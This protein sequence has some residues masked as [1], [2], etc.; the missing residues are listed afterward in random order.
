[1]KCLSLLGCLALFACAKSPTNDNAGP[2]GGGGAGTAGTSGAGSGAGATATPDAAAGTAGTGGSSDSAIVGGALAVSDAAAGTVT[3]SG[4]AASGGA[5]SPSTYP[6]LTGPWNSNPA[7][8]D[9]AAQQGQLATLT[10]LTTDQLIARSTGAMSQPLG[11]APESATWLDL[12]QASA[13]ALNDQELAAY[14]KNGFVISQRQKYAN[15]FYGYQTIYAADL[16]IYVSADSILYALHRSYDRILMTVESSYLSSTLKQL[17]AGLRTSLATAGIGDNS[18]HD[19]GLLLGVAA[20]LLDSQATGI[21]TEM[22][23][24]INKATVAAGMDTVTLFGTDR[25]I[26]FSQFTPRGHYNDGGAMAQYFRA[27]M[28]LGRTELRLVDV[29]SSGKR[30]LVRREIEDVLA[31]DELV[32]PD[33]RAQWDSIE[34]IITL[35]VGEAD[36]MTLPQ[37][38]QLHDALGIAVS[39]DL[40]TITDQKLL[41]TIDAGN[42]GVQRICSQLM[43]VDDG[44]TTL[45][46]SFAFMG[47]RYTVDSNVFTK[48][49]YPNVQE[50]M[51]PNPLDVAFAALGND[52]AAPLLRSEL[53]TYGYAPS[54]AKAR[55]LVEWHDAG[56]W[57]SSLYTFWLSALRELSAGKYDAT[58]LPAIARTEAWGR[59]LLNTQLASWAELRHNTVLYAKQSFTGMALCE[60]PDGYVDPYPG[61]YGRLRELGTMAVQRLAQVLPTT[62]GTDSPAVSYFRTLADVASRLESLANEELAGATRTQADLDFLNDAV[63]TKRQSVGCSSITVP[64]GWYAKLFYLGDDALDS[65]PTIVDVHTQ[66]TDAGGAVVGRVLHV[67]TGNPRLMVLSVDSCQGPRAYAGVVSAYFEQITDNFKRMTDQ[68][69]SAQINAATPDDV[70]W[71]QDLIVR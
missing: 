31:L 9:R 34:Q 33:L 39:T 45:P 22:K 12:I 17:L 36:Y 49:V 3:G 28:W 51:M 61:M 19:L 46:N 60:Y 70:P 20:G 59:R 26:D 47:Q 35:F 63:V 69:W 40:A 30:V 54:L 8:A 48:V 21:D 24:L 56:Y 4:G 62:S 38:Q 2:A 29:D 32:T 15:F 65:N 58:T 66:P 5:V 42:Y 14:K 43:E 10:S 27:M 55:Q 71:M 7:P 18:Q 23:T 25:M 67:A 68:E 16:P 57:D 11:Y 13:L 52:Q 37:V 64:S 50:R 53:D 44:V 6:A 1:M 41:D